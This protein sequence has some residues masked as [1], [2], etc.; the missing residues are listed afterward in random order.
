MFLMHTNENT[1]LKVYRQE[2]ADK[3]LQALARRDLAR[4]RE[5]FNLRRRVLRAILL[6]QE[7]ST[8]DPVRAAEHIPLS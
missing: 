1:R 3:Y 8:G 4:A 7:W 5:L 6:R 2:L